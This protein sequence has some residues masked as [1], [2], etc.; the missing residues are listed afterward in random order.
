MTTRT[1]KQQG[2]AYGSSAIT[3]VA[4]IN[5]VEVFNGSV[6]ALDQPLPIMPLAEGTTLPMQDLFSWT[7]DVNYAG[8]KTMEVTVTGGTLLLTTIV[9]NY[10]IIIN[11]ENPPPGVTSGADVFGQY[12]RNDISDTQVSFDPKSNVAINGQPQTI[13]RDP[14]LTGQFYWTIPTG[15]TFTADVAIQPGYETNPEPIPGPGI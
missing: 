7:D 9:A 1:F 13:V 10:V 4:K 11:T 3:M 12:Y 15:S 5:G 2:Q 6:P 8:T 14:D